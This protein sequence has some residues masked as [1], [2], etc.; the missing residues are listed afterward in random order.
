MN[1]RPNITTTGENCIDKCLR[2]GQQYYW[3]HKETT[4]WGFC[5]PDFLIKRTARYAGVVEDTKVEPPQ[6]YTAR[7]EACRDNCEYHGYTYTW[8]HKV[9]PSNLGNWR[10]SDYCTTSPSKL[11]F[12]FTFQSCF[13]TINKNFL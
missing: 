7:G 11:L 4:L 6:G 13:F 2:R 8:C 10:T 5:T 3:C 1:F 12:Y 9:S